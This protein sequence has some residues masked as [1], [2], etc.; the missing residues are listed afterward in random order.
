MPQAPPDDYDDQSADCAE[1]CG[2]HR[3][4]LKRTEKVTDAAEKND[5]QH[6]EDLKVN[7][8]APL[9]GIARHVDTRICALKC[10][11]ILTLRQQDCNDFRKETGCGETLPGIWKREEWPA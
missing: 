5:G 7:H 8:G 1:T 2:R 4:K 9:P 11:T 6:S 3:I 10:Q